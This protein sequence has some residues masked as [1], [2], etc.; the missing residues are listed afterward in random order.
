M[1]LLDADD[2]RSCLLVDLVNPRLVRLKKAVA[3]A[4]TIVVLQCLA[5]VAFT[6]YY[7]YSSLSNDSKLMDG[8]EA[9]KFGMDS[10]D[11]GLCGSFTEGKWVL[12]SLLRSLPPIKV[13]RSRSSN[14]CSGGM[15]HVTAL[16]FED[17]QFEVGQ[18][19][20][21]LKRGR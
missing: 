10:P 20:E 16:A 9:L 3:L 4:V 18:T 1:P 8:N 15:E 19:V 21:A 6:L 17:S 11:L 5:F 7:R 13:C 2:D 14:T 12:T